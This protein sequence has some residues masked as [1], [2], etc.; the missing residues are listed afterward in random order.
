MK[1]LRLPAAKAHYPAWY[2]SALARTE[3]ATKGGKAA[4]ALRA[5]LAAT[6]P[7]GRQ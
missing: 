7:E 1:A 5:K 6:A 4:D 2:R 3:R